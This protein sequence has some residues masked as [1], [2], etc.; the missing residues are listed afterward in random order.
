M[1]LRFTDAE[2]TAQERDLIEATVPRVE[3]VEHPGRV[4]RGGHDARSQRH[5]LLPALAAVQAG[6]GHVSEGALMEICRRLTVPP[7]EAYGVASFYALISTEPRPPRIAHLCDDV[8]C[9][10]FGA[11]EVI[12]EV[13]RRLGPAGASTD[14]SGWARSPCLGQCDRAPAA[15]LQRAGQEDAVVAGADVS[16]VDHLVAALDDHPVTAPAVTVPQQGEPGLRLLARIGSV[17]PTSLVDHRVHGGGEALRRALELGPDGVRAEVATANLRGRGGAAFPTAVKW[18]AVAAHD[19]PKYLICNADE[20]EPGTFK[21][22][23][24]LEGDPYRLLEAM[25]IA[26]YATGCRIGYLYVRGEYPVATR[27][28]ADAIATSRQAGLLGDDVAGAGFAFDVELR[29]GQGA[30]ICG[31]E[32]AL[33]ES[34]EGHRGEPRNKPPFP[35]D[36]GLFGRPTVVNNVETLLNVTDIVLEGG[37]AFAELGTRDSTGTRLFCL[38]G[39][40]AVPGV[41]EVTYG[42]TLG[43]LLE[44]AGGVTGELAAVLLGGAAGSFV[45]AE[46]LDVPLT[47]E[48]TRERGL[49]LGSGVVMPFDAGTD[50]GRVVARIAAFFRDETCGQCVP[51][52]VGVVRQEEALVRYLSNGRET[53][54][55]ELLG[56]IDRAM[57]DASI[58]GLG[59]T[60]ASAVRSAIAQRLV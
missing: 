9:G 3:V 30:Y 59:Q 56:D 35:T 8:G 31:E 52:R 18:D 27:R 34:I 58:C 7:A 55:L 49:A 29:R 14:G 54:E 44:R 22:R 46:H 20:S 51:C 36:T 40:I 50:L 38:S 33:M 19:D 28:L 21:D 17:D 47:F 16:D 60:A 23:V 10:P 13:Q 6:I 11:D 43:A 5:L 53:V 25:T 37:Q 26:A 15:Y 32:T 24:L 12:A 48:A 2:P 1:D 4:V 57:T 45:T 42:E 41:Y 39:A